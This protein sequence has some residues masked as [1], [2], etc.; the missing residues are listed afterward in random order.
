MLKKNPFFLNIL[1]T[2]ILGLCL[3]AIWVSRKKDG[4]GG[5]TTYEK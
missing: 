2:A 5:N 1:L 3:L 4:Q